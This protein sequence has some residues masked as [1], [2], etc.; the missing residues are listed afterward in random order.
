M[1]NKLYIV[2]REDNGHDIYWTQTG[3]DS[4][5]SEDYRKKMQLNYCKAV[6]EE[7]LKITCK[8]DREAKSCQLL[9]NEV[10][11]PWTNSAGY[12]CMQICIDRKPEEFVSLVKEIVSSRD[13][14]KALADIVRP[15][16][17]YYDR[18]HSFTIGKMKLYESSEQGYI[19]LVGCDN[20]KLK[21]GKTNDLARRFEELKECERVKAIEIV[22]SFR[23]NRMSMDEAMLHLL[24]RK[25]KANGNSE[26]RYEQDRGNS[27]LFD[28]NGD[29]M[30]IW[31]WYKPK[32]I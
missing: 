28:N 30:E 18:K 12:K 3:M 7:V 27:E 19:Y 1:F 21:I 26:N 25:F 5:I 22:D 2:H 14:S 9:I 17:E 15:L 20:G 16:Y 29:V 6:F 8:D 13:D 10:F 23:T 11:K 24:C 31:N 4:R 32:N